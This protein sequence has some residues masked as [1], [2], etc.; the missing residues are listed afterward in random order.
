MKHG[1]SYWLI[2]I[3]SVLLLSLLAN[4][5]V[6]VYKAAMEQEAHFNDKA[7]IALA[8]IVE[9]VSENNKVCKTMNSCIK[10]GKVGFCSLSFKDKEE[11]HFVDSIVQKN[12]AK[13][14]IDLAYNFD[15]CST[16]HKSTQ[17]PDNKET[18]SKNIDNRQQES[19]L[20]MYLEFPSK[21]KYVLKQMGPAFVSSLLIIIL[22]TIIFIVVFRF[23][24]REKR[25]A[26]RTRDFLNTMTHEFKT[27]LA[28]ISFAN[29]ML[30]RSASELDTEKIQKYTE[31]IRSENDKIVKN[32]EDILEMARQEYDLSKVQEEIINVHELL[33]E[34]KSTFLSANP[35][36][37]FNLNFSAHQPFVHGKMS[38]LGNA[39]S[40]IIDN[41]I[42]YSKL[43][44]EI[45]I[46]TSNDPDNGAL[47]IAIEDN[48]IGIHKK[49]QLAVFDKFY[50]VSTGDQHDV[51]GFGLGLAYVKQIIE[52]M[53][54]TVSLKSHVGKGSVFTLKL[55]SSHAS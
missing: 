54:G 23:Y 40:N 44:P 30:A 45:Q 8:S 43:V 31:I 2:I 27:P 29:N 33:A 1:K 48:G 9:E 36:I 16:E 46:S 4:Q 3:I 19:G 26:E 18:F 34:L 47:L 25:N 11:W 7:N 50:R 35:D 20:I 12:L 10:G 6:Y 41:A 38:F 15:F 52:H 17:L 32:S 24:I 53:K 51:K 21:S 14:N 22:L 49:N 13:S 55:P 37:A 39:I 5:I 42:K 28:N